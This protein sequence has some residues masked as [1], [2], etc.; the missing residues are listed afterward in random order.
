MCQLITEELGE[1]CLAEKTKETSATLNAVET[2]RSNEGEETDLLKVAELL[3]QSKERVEA[4]NAKIRAEVR[5]LKEW[6]KN[7]SDITKYNKA[8]LIDYVQNC[9]PHIPSNMVRKKAYKGK[10]LRQCVALTKKDP[11][12]YPPLAHK[13]CE[14][15]LMRLQM[16][17]RYAKEDLGV[18]SVNPAKGV[19]IPKNGSST[20][21][22]KGYTAKEQKALWNALKGVRQEEDKRPARFWVPILCLYHGFRLNEVCSL[23]LKDVYEDEDGVWV[24][25][26]N[27]DGKGKKLKNKSSVRLVPVHPYVLNDLGFKAFVEAQKEERKKGLLFSDLTFSEGCGYRRRI[28]QWFAKWKVSWLPTESL[29]KHAHD[30]RYTFIQQAQNQAKMSDRCSQEITGHAVEGVSSVHLEYS[31]RLKP[32]AVLEELEKLRYGWEW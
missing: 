2:S 21:K 6:T 15:T 1:S 24:M 20:K 32:K 23:F 18:I 16:V 7:K 10:T 19:E 11:E 30:L 3:I 5:H 17:F 4:T 12:K 22:P 26:V 25:D 29:H 14:N 8:D 9:L 31:G 28:S 27:V 13:T